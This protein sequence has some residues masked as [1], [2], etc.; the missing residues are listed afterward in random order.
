MSVFGD[1]HKIEEYRLRVTEH[2]EGAENPLD[3][4]IYLKL[5]PLTHGLEPEVFLHFDSYYSQMSGTLF[6]KGIFDAAMYIGLDTPRFD[7]IY[8]V[9][10]S[11]KPVYFTYSVAANWTDPADKATNIDVLRFSIHTLL[12]P[13]GEVERPQSIS[14]LRTQGTFAELKKML[15]P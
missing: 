5:E 14:G 7:T 9:L 10:R 1:T 3:R 13:V 15:T 6:K 12:E 8:A 11:E 2:V 4:L